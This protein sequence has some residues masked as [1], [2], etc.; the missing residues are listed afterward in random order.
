MKR[1]FNFATFILLLGL[2]VA[3]AYIASGF[4][5]MTDNAFVV[6]LSTPVTPKVTG[7]VVEVLVK[8]GEMVEVGQPLF[9]LDDETYSLLL[10]QAHAN[11]E[12]A[13]L[14]AEVL[15][16]QIEV[17]R[18][19]LV[20]GQEN[21]AILEY[22]LQQKSHRSV[23][24]AVPQ[25]ELEQLRHEVQAQ[26]ALVGAM[27]VS[28]E[29]D[30]LASR[31]AAART[32]ALHALLEIA[33]IA[34]QDTVVRARAAGMVQNV[35]LSLGSAVNPAEPVFSIVDMSTALVQA[36]ISESDLSGLKPGDKVSIYPRTYLLQKSFEGTVLS[37]P[38]DV[39]RQLKLPLNA[40]Q[41]V[42]SEN[43]WLQLPQRFPVLIRI[44][45]TDPKYPLYGGMSAFVDVHD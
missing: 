15:E 2:A 8:N 14:N 43:K 22:K 25:I 41:M 4:F 20:V 28:V 38:F 9:K 37:Q 36:N 35:F 3:G 6:R 32:K 5:V 7:T 18:F 13:N 19:N 11:H 26:R 39:N 34:V 29:R 44:N 10:K 12:A 16:K 31:E 33:E 27:A 23:R 30:A 42:L 40:G 17:A 24:G 45:N 1:H 21:L